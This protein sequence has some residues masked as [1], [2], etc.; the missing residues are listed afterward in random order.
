M[1]QLSANN[2][3]VQI[4]HQ[5]LFQNLMLDFL[6]GEIWG[7]FGPNG[8]GKTTLLHTLAGLQ[9]PSEGTIH[10][11][12]LPISKVK[13]RQ[14]AS[15]IGVLLQDTEF[16]FP[17]SV[18]DFALSGRHPHQRNWLSHTKEDL[19]ITHQ[20]LV[21]VNLD[22]FSKR[23]VTNLSG[24]EKR[25]LAIAALLT[26]QPNIYLL[27]EPTNHL[28]LE[29]KFRILSLFKALAKSEQKIVIM[30]LHDIHLIQTFCDKAII[31]NN[32]GKN[33]V[34]KTQDLFTHANL[35]QLFSQDFL[36]A[37]SGYLDNR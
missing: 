4:N 19:E 7:I 26:Q 35:S 9:A 13:P 34:G 36:N 23:L 27:D 33:K 14:R 15:E 32:S 2:I 17:H 11:N 21:Q 8:A 31:F 28:D 1:S 16:S 12:N 30:I 25:R 18:M 22:R 10:L 29:Q 24:G 37:C 5:F 3:G 6:P 20:A